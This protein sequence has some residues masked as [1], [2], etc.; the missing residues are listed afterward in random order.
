MDLQYGAEER[1]TREQQLL[2]GVWHITHVRPAPRY[3]SKPGCVI[4]LRNGYG[5]KSYFATGFTFILDQVRE[6]SNL[7]TLTPEER[8]G[9][10]YSIQE[11]RQRGWGNSPMLEILQIEVM[12][13]A[14]LLDRPQAQGVECKNAESL[15]EVSHS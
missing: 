6:T 10:V 12:P 1:Q 7:D 2:K 4:R 5:P 11:M 3:P 8:A 13:S 14:F 15:F 9:L